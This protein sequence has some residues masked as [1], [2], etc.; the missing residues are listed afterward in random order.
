MT[1]PAN[2]AILV[3][4]A[5]YEA[6][7]AALRRARHIIDR[8]A[9]SRACQGDPESDY[10]RE[11]FEVLEAIDAVLA[12]VI[13]PQPAATAQLRGETVDLDQFIDRAPGATP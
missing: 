7:V 9:D 10:A 13:A 2:Q 11:P 8:E 5:D 4:K 1:A 6:L 3:N 12:K